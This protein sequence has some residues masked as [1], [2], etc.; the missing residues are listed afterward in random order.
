MG[1]IQNFKIP[2]S[3]LLFDFSLIC[4]LIYVFWPD[5]VGT[6][7]DSRVYIARAIEYSRG[8]WLTLFNTDSIVWNRRPGFPA[9]TSLAFSVFGKSIKWAI[10]PVRL[11]FVGTA[12]AIYYFFRQSEAPLLGFIG[13]VYVL[14]LAVLNSTASYLWAD[15]IVAFFFLVFQFAIFFGYNSAVQRASNIL[16]LIAGILFC[17]GVFTKQTATVG[18]L[19][20]FLLLL[21]I[22]DFRNRKNYIALTIF[23]GVVLLAIVPFAWLASQYDTIAPL[24]ISWISR[25]LN[26][27]V[28]SPTTQV[29]NEAVGNNS[30]SLVL[31]LSNRL[32]VILQ[33]YYQNNFVTKIFF[34]A[35]APIT[36]LGLS[37]LAVIK[38]QKTAI[39]ALC[40]AFC[41][42]PLILFQGVVN[43]GPR[44][45]TYMYLVIGFGLILCLQAIGEALAKLTK[46]NQLLI[47]N[48][49]TFFLGSI[50][51]IGNIFYA[52]LP[53]KA[54]WD[55]SQGDFI[56][57]YDIYGFGTGGNLPF[58]NIPVWGNLDDNY[59]SLGS[60]IRNTGQCGN[61]LLTHTEQYHEAL[62]V[63]LNTDASHKKIETHL[64]PRVT[65]HSDKDDVQPLSSQNAPL[66]V[67]HQNTVLYAMFEAEIVQM[68]N[69]HQLDCALVATDLSF[70]NL[71]FAN[72]AHF[73]VIGQFGDAAYTLYKVDSPV[74]SQPA[75]PQIAI[76]VHKY[77]EELQSA[78][79]K[80]ATLLA[81][82]TSLS[83]PF[84]KDLTCQDNCALPRFSSTD[85]YHQPLATQLHDVTPNKASLTGQLITNERL[86]ENY[87]TQTLHS[88]DPTVQ[89]SFTEALLET[90]KTTPD[91]YTAI[92]M[93]LVVAD[94]HMQK[95]EF[96]TAKDLLQDA[97]QKHSDSTRLAYAVYKVHRATNQDALALDSLATLMSIYDGD[98]SPE[99]MISISN[100]LHSIDQAETAILYLEDYLVWHAY[101]EKIRLHLANI[102]LRS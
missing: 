78:P 35:I 71:Y 58:T 93:V 61:G 50:L 17:L 80:R 95:G 67:W 41:F 3:R 85:Q 102:Y 86:S 91:T 23:S 46:A 22:P 14:T 47:K 28:G 100:Y 82:L 53:Y 75:V 8:E 29:A 52:P 94:T 65:L 30:P 13:A 2:K 42:T 72:N 79:E 27:V 10:L 77:F 12:A 57:Q 20:P 32:L 51:I 43:W 60:W 9:F 84:A 68:I 15:I 11:A 4:I 69:T 49:T 90:A 19:T 33:N 59:E 66:F 64:I 34:P 36:L 55:A 18:I 89:Q 31:T 39:L 73:S 98:L 92:S 81:E 70:L 26:L 54:I 16:A 7:S 45:N 74:N 88:L 40:A 87:L 48:G 63:F 97:Y 44:Q 83:E 38:K 62:F 25:I 5:G 99:Q 6:T 1:S 96:S 76:D 21:L 56:N 24:G 37:A 101:S